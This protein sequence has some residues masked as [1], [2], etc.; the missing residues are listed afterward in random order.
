MITTTFQNLRIK[1]T[2]LLVTLILPFVLIVTAVETFAADV[3]FAD[4]RG[5]LSSEPDLTKIDYRKVGGKTIEKVSLDGIGITNE[6]TLV[7]VVPGNWM[8]KSDCLQYARKFSRI[9]NDR[10]TSLFWSWRSERENQRIRIDAL[11]K[12]ARSDE[13]GKVLAAFIRELPSEQKV[14]LV[15]FSFGARVVCSAVQE[16][17]TNEPTTSGKKPPRINVALLAPAFD[18]VWVLPKSKFGNVFTASDK[19]TVHYNPNDSTLHFYPLMYG[20]IG[21]RRE[22]LGY[23]GVPRNA[24]TPEIRGKLLQLNASRVLGREHGF[25]S[26]FSTF[27]RAKNSADMLK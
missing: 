26:S 12:A 1:L 20:L 3:F 22:A 21:P 4:T 8:S 18:A 14:T 24:I 5:I 23:V 25:W 2:T 11:I 6:K 17:S 16:L 15:G 19:V 7:V 13:Q 9:N 27:I 10:Y